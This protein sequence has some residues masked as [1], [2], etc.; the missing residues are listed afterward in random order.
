MCYT[1]MDISV[2]SWKTNII[3]LVRH[4]V[5]SIACI[6]HSSELLF[7]VLRYF[8]APKSAVIVIVQSNAQHMS[9]IL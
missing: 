3:E 9:C 4:C 6:F 8:L 1:S 5:Y 7:G 2:I